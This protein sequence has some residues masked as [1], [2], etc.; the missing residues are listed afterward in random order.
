MATDSGAKDVVISDEAAALF[1]LMEHQ[2]AI[3]LFTPK[4]VDD[5]L[6]ERLINAATRAPSARNVQAWR[7]IVVRDKAIKTKI[8]DI[9]DELGAKLLGYPLDPSDARTRWSDVPVLIAAC[10][11]E[12]EDAE[13]RARFDGSSIFPAVQNLLLAIQAVGLGALLTTRWRMREA[14]V[15]DAMGIPDNYRLCAIVP[16]GW[17]QKPPGRNRRKPVS[18]VTYRDRFGNGW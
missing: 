9:F 3:R 12:P 17:P 8:G 14:E 1:E 11:E 10:T 5:A 2:R 7:F 6:I 18:E 4:D 13:A 16:V 15:K